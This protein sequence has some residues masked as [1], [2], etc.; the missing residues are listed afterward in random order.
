MSQ[1]LRQTQRHSL[2]QR[3]ISTIALLSL[4]NADLCDE[5]L[6]RAQVNPALRVRPPRPVIAANASDEVAAELGLYGHI[7]PQIGLILARG[8]EQAIGFA[9]LDALDGNGWLAR[10]LDEI[11]RQLAQPLDVVERVLVRLQLGVEPCGLFGRSLADCL[12]LQAQDAGCLGPELVLILHH[13]PLLSQGK[14]AFCQRL[15][16]DI[17][18]LERALAQLRRFS[19]RPGAALSAADPALTRAPD[20]SV[21]REGKGWA[22]RLNRSTLPQ[23]GVTTLEPGQPAARALHLEAIWL[24][25]LFARRNRTVLALARAVLRRQRDFLTEGPAALSPLSRG[26][27]A[28]ELGLHPSTVGR[29]AQDLWIETPFGLQ[30]LAGFFSV[31]RV[32]APLGAR[33]LAPSAIRHRLAAL[34]QAEDPQAPFSDQAL[35]EALAAQG[36]PLARRTISKFREELGL[37]PLATRRAP[38]DPSRS[39]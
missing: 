26:E 8:P 17:A 23:V 25:D 37:G 5:L 2:A 24:C 18:T 13:L 14:M 21:L 16:V 11:A 7:A 35:S 4:S 22:L 1:A 9:L 19:P 34:I 31:N 29:I 20:L 32:A 39:F 12:R 28:T 3:Q 30:K 33:A 15:G 6:Q 27:I 10:P 36:I 38:S